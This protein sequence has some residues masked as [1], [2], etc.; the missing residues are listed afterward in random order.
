M[1][2]KQH[3]TR[4]AMGAFLLGSSLVMGSCGD[5]YTYFTINMGFDGLTQPVLS[6]IGRCS[7]KIESGG[8]EVESYDLGPVDEN[9]TKWGCASGQTKTYIGKMNYSALR[10]AGTTM[11]FILTGKTDEGVNSKDVA[12]G[13][14]EAKTAPGSQVILDVKATKL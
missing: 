7:L 9:G 2:I 6:S 8:K 11:K 3:G 4:L 1:G 12:Q 14:N 5:E 10:P 13:F